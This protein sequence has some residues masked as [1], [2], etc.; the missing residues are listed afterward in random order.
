ML[1]VQPANCKACSPAVYP[2]MQGH[3]TNPL[4]PPDERFESMVPRR[5]RVELQ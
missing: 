4:L 2:G 1:F 3:A 5:K